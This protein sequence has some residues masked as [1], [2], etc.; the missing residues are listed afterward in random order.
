MKENNKCFDKFGKEIKVGD[1]I[2][3]GLGGMS[4]FKVIDFGSGMIVLRDSFKEEF[5]VP[6]S[7][8]SRW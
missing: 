1:Y 6:V 8:V 4:T 7:K 3:V 5:T 2:R